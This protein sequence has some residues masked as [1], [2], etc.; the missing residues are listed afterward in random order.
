M[1]RKISPVL[2]LALVLNACTPATPTAPPADGWTLDNA[3]SRL[4]FVST[5]NDQVSETHRFGAFEATVSPQGEAKLSITLAS[6][7]T[8]IPIRDERL[9]A[10]LFDV[11]HYGTAT[12]TTQVDA[13][14]AAALPIGSFQVTTSDA[15][16]DLHGVSAALPVEL[17]VTRI[18]A[19][20]WLVTSEKPVIVNA[21]Q[22]HLG[23]GIEALRAAANLQSIANGVP[24]TFALVFNAP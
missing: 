22:F 12:I 14:A 3:A 20:R 24:V 10:L 4:A 19:K 21:G 13:A 6:A 1:I 11:E 7:E 16:L 18:A 9:R 15:T 5:K 17:R 8:G 23:E 2:M